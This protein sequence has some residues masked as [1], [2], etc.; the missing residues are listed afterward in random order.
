MQQ[1]DDERALAALAHI[2]IIANVA[3]FAGLMIAA[4]IWATQR[5]RSAY[6]RGH[7]LQ[8]MI[9][10]LFVLAVAVLLSLAWAG[11]L[12]AS[13]LPVALRPE[14]FRDGTLPP[15]FWFALFSATLPL[16]V[17]LVA[18]LIGVYGGIQTY[19]GRRFRYPL[20]GRLLRD[21]PQDAPAPIVAVELATIVAA[22]PP[23]IVVVELAPI[24]P[25]AAPD[26]IAETVAQPTPPAPPAAEPAPAEPPVAKAE[27]LAAAP[28]N[29]GD[30]EQP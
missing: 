5:E 7:A 1:K 27:E 9:F 15:I 25:P 29:T 8:A 4:T 26:V 22:S 20:A 19:R 11:C 3:G 13:L 6:V 23:T 28:A 18:L 2:S 24:A 14:L 30:R 16:A 12:V 17:G 21:Q 10:Q